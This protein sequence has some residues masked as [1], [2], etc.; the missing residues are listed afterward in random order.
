[1]LAAGDRAIREKTLLEFFVEGWILPTN[2]FENHRRV[3]LFFIPVMSKDFSKF[4]ILTSIDPLV[5]PVHCFQFLH[6]RGNG[7]VHIP[8]F[9]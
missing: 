5:L 4:G 2:P 1:M 8:R 7:T 3:L 9:L 6:Q